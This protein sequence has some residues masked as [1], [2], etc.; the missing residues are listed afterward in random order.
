MTNQ[1]SNQAQ[2]QDYS[3]AEIPASTSVGADG[4]TFAMFSMLSASV[5]AKQQSSLKVD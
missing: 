4:S 2:L 3:M 5:S 1:R